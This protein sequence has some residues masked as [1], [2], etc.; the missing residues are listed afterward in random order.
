MS[1]GTE[2]KITRLRHHLNSKELAERLGIT[3]AYMSEIENDKAP[4][5]TLDLFV[6]ICEALDVTL[7]Q[8]L[9]YQPKD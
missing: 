8:L 3:R 1:L 5:L 6:R 4:E 7:N 9:N 2:I